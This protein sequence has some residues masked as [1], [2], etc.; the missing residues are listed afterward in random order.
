MLQDH[1]SLT[2][3]DLCEHFKINFIGL[4]ILGG[5]SLNSYHLQPLRP[6]ERARIG[7]LSTR[8]RHI[9]LYK[10]AISGVKGDP[11]EI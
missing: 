2:V 5:Q 1:D 10:S 4:G 6:L 11:E 3:F 7:N 8:H 9:Q